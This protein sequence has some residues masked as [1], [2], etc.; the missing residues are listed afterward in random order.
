M[1]GIRPGCTAAAATL[2]TWSAAPGVTGSCSGSRAL[3]SSSMSPPAHGGRSWSRDTGGL[4]LGGGVG[5]VVRASL[6]SGSVVPTIYGA[7]IPDLRGD[8][9]CATSGGALGHA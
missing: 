1:A 2:V 5:L 9:A 8:R 4:G 6:V 3:S 7:D